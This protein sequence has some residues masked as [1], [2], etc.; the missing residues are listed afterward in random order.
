MPDTTWTTMRVGGALPSDKIEALLEAIENDFSY[1]CQEA[2]DDEEDLRAIVAKGESVKLQAHVYGN[3]D[4]VV[5]F[6]KENGL[7]FWMH[8][9]AGYE[10]DAFISIWAPGMAKEEECPASGQG[11]TPQV[12]L[13]TLRTWAGNGILMLIKDVERFE[14]ERVPPLTITEMVEDGEPF[15]AITPSGDRLDHWDE[16]LR[17]AD[18]TPI[19]R[20]VPKVEKPDVR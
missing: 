2:P 10:W 7:P 14:S 16:R 8:C 20:M 17:A 15:G 9:E 3:P 13:S 12:D 4:R 19:Y 18:C 6:C 11:Y 1:E 5:A